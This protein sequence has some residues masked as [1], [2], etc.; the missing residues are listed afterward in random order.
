MEFACE[1]IWCFENFKDTT[2]SKKYLHK[3]LGLVLYKIMFLTCAHFIKYLL[4]QRINSSF[5]NHI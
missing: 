5:K 1:A 2:L 4:L 3:Y